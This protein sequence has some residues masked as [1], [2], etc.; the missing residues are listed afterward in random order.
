MNMPI[1]FCRVFQKQYGASAK[2]LIQEHSLRGPLKFE[3][4]YAAKG[5][6][7]MIALW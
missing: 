3:N 6:R 5:Y 1:L 4:S 2:I 7:V